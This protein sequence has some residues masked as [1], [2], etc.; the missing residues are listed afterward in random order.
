MDTLRN[1]IAGQ[2]STSE[3]TEAI[4]RCDP[5]TGELVAVVPA[6]SV[7]DV[8]LAVSAAHR[9]QRPWAERSVDERVAWIAAAADTLTSHV[10]ELATIEA[11]EMGK[12]IP[13]GESFIRTGI[14]ALRSSAVA[15][16]DYP[17]TAHVKTGD[18]G[19]VTT[20]VRKPLGVVAVI[21]PWNFTVTQVLIA[22]GPL[23]AAGNTVVI[24]PS[25]KATPSAV[26][27]IELLDFPAG[28]VNLVL[29]DSRAGAPLV[30]HPLVRLVHFT[31]SVRS[32]RSV[33]S[34]AGADLKRAMLELG[35]NDP[36]IVDADVDVMDVAQRVALGSFVNSGQICTSMERIYVHRDVAEPFIE[37]LV[38]NARA[39]TLGPATEPDT[40]LGPMVD[41]DQRAIVHR[42]ITDAVEKGARLLVGGKVVDGPGFFYPATV[43][44]D[45]DHTM[46]VM[47]EETFGPVAAVQVVDSFDEALMLAADSD[48]GLAM[49]VYTR[50]VDHISRA[51]QINTGVL[52]VNEWQGGDFSRLMEPAGNSGFGATGGHLAYDAATRPMAVHIAVTQ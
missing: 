12:P 34:A 48:Y 29:G 22:I 47:T 30:E 41:D 2:W 42:Q 11:R 31:G 26:R 50:S 25:E 43:L 17:F 15:A 4:T 52:W 46:A 13:V 33:G 27:M 39:H 16:L 5:S 40:V 49:T 20:V 21:V 18:D 24:K 51:Q 45:V 9:A 38:E 6:G 36:V 32:G 23:L 44:V 10:T 8:D 1:F 19:L 35:G 7:K 14:D 28:V 37:A 3:S